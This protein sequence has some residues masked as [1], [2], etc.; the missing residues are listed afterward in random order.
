MEYS[1]PM[2]PDGVTIKVIIW[3]V[4]GIAGLLIAMSKLPREKKLDFRV[5]I[6]IPLF[7]VALFVLTATLPGYAVG[8]SL[9]A[10][11]IM[12]GAALLLNRY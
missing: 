2:E 12:A 5:I 10:T 6:G 3:A 11:M 1:V 9:V 8:F 4:V 7:G